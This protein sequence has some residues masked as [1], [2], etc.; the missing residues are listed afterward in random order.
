METL[1]FMT[2][3]RPT[4]TQQEQSLRCFPRGNMAC[5]STGNQQVRLNLSLHQ[6]LISENGTDDVI[7]RSENNN[8]NN[9]ENHCGSPWFQVV[10]YISSSLQI[11]GMKT[12]SLRVHHFVF[13]CCC[14]LLQSL[15][16]QYS[17]IYVILTFSIYNIM[18]IQ[19][20]GHIPQ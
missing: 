10:E 19:I 18:N 4:S 13:F 15:Q 7:F 9:A 8:R 1:D 6:P 12:F 20:I 14:L 2:T 16:I 3:A 11:H 5:S 17:L